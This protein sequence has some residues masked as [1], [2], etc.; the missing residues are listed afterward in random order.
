MRVLGEGGTGLGDM[1]EI[2]RLRC[3]EFF[4]VAVTTPSKERAALSLEFF[5]K[6]AAV[7]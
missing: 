6:V 7:P 1:V 4:W 5:C 2:Q 3:L